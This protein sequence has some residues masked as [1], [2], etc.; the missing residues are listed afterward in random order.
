MKTIFAE[1]ITIGDEILYGQITN[2]NSQFISSELDKIGIKVSRQVSVSDKG[3]DI[4]NAITDAETR[5]DVV[6]MTGGLGPTKDDIT[7]K[8]LAEYFDSAMHTDE[9]VMEW[10]HNFFT[11]RGR[12]LSELNKMQALVPDKCQVIYNDW[13][14]APAMWFEKEGKI[15]ISMPG[16]PSEMKNLMTN[17]IIPNLQQYFKT[18]IILHKIVH[19]IGIGESM[20]A[21]K[22]ADWE[23]NLPQNMGLAYLPNY[24]QVR[25]RLTGMGDDKTI[26]EQQMQAQMDT[27]LPQ[28]EKYIFGFDND[29][30]E[31]VV[32][33]LLLEKRKTVST[34]ES[35]TGGHVGHLFTKIA[36]SS[37]Y[38]EGGIIS[39]TNDIKIK[40]LGVNPATLD[41]FGA[42]SEQTVREMAEG[43]R[44]KMGT[45]IGLAT[46]GVA[47]PDG[48]NEQTPVG[49]V[50]IAYSDE[51]KTLARKLTLVNDRLQ[52]IQFASLL[53]LEFMRKNIN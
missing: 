39:Y 2:T 7:K 16:V 5:A 24:I 10:L 44:K 14:T 23:D 27:L 4:K 11:K 28:I 53:L 18:P 50:W 22:I 29:T 33:H 36:G 40:L 3:N 6:L 26:L 48:G 45:D 15:F 31:Q 43:V 37:R 20:I 51:N 12:E 46:T 19:T 13:G 21:E 30:L 52:N 35:C 49:T 1:I 42:V 8:T 34:A 9:K 41:E 38:Y 25:L 32:A 47:G 17:K